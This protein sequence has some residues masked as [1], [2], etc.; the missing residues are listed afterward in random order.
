MRRLLGVLSAAGLLAGVLAGCADQGGEESAPPASPT[1]SSQ[2]SGGQLTLTGKVQSGVEGGCLVLQHD[3]TLYLL[4]GAKGVRPGDEVTVTG[5]VST[6]T[7][8]FCQQGTPFV[9]DE[10]T[11]P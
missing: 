8:S 4:L 6:G 9:V 1:S 3:R 11:T 5:H 7:M 10:V 2:T